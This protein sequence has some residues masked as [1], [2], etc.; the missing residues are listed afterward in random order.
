MLIM[1]KMV[2]LVSESYGEPRVVKEHMEGG[3]LTEF[4]R[5][6]IVSEVSILQHIEVVNQTWD[7]K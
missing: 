4:V 1:L 3:I 7:S 6:N 5:F 2:R